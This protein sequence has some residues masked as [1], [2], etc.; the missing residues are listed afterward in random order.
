MNCLRIVYK[1]ADDTGPARVGVIW[2]LDMPSLSPENSDKNKK[3]L[4]HKGE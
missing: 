3:P 1:W 4:S 2:L